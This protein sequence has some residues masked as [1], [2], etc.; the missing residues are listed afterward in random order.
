VGAVTNIAGQA[1]LDP[2]LAALVRAQEKV[3]SRIGMHEVK[4]QFY[5]LLTTARDVERRKA[6]GHKVSASVMHM[7]FTG[8]PGTGKTT[9]ADALADAYYGL[10][11]VKRDHVERVANSMDLTSGIHGQT[12][13]KTEEIF[14][15][16]KGGVLYI[17]EFGKLVDN[18]RREGYG[19]D[20][21]AK[22]LTLMEQNNDTVVIFAGYPEDFEA[23]NA[24]DPGFASRFRNRVNFPDYSDDEMVEMA[25][26]IASTER[27]HV[28][29][30]DALKVL[31]TAI[32][33]YNQARPGENA[34]GIRN[35]IDNAVD[36][37]ARRLA[38]WE[39]AGKTITKEE[40]VVLR[41]EDFG[42]KVKGS[43]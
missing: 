34:R 6:A 30:A 26:I 21:L 32:E 2:K 33:Q 41:P 42:Y 7:A 8:N 39:D 43:S 5:G 40:M 14:N 19:A 28:I 12:A 11:L 15:R 38:A 3:D 4:E 27:N 1:G 31:P 35:L 29:H 37:K 9:I 23:L 17:D 25:P 24:H 36:K 22:L 10:G 16:A 18:A 13:E 20:A